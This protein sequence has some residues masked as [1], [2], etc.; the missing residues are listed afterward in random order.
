MTIM[1]R[2]F[3][4]APAEGIALAE[5]IIHS[6][7]NHLIVFCRERG[8]GGQVEFIGIFISNV[9][10]RVSRLVGRI[11]FNLRIPSGFNKNV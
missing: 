3:H 11:Y 5:R 10:I 7:E 8:A 9:F 2:L 4:A 6:G 1:L